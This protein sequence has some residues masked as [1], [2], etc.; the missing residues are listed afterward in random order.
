MREIE[1][2][3][4]GIFDGK[5]AYGGISNMDPS[6]P[7][8]I[9]KNFNEGES[10]SAHVVERK[11]VGEYTGLKD[12]N[13]KKIYEAD[14]FWWNGALREVVYREDKA[15]F[16]GKRIQGNGYTDRFFYLWHLQDLM[17]RVEVI[18]NIYENPE[19]LK[20]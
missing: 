4:L 6:A 15:A 3:G 12:K 10:P 19:L 9:T 17:D 14:L 11:T 7:A 20:Q 13:G 2:R 16:M 5:W 18:G 1:F 8:I